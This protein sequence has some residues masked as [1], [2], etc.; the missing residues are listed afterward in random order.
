M[1]NRTKP[2]EDPHPKC[3]TPESKLIRKYE[4]SAKMWIQALNSPIERK[5]TLNKHK[6]INENRKHR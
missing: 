4:N 6:Y 3:M 2:T 5:K 1:S